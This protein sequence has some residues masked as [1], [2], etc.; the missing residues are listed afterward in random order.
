M[1]SSAVPGLRVSA[2]DVDKLSYSRDLWPRRLLE[3][4][5][6]RMHSEPGCIAWP[7]TSESVARLVEFARREG[8]HL[9]PF[10]AGSGVC[11]AV[12]PDARTVVV[13]LKEMAGFDIEPE[14][15]TLDVGP[16]AMGI[17]LE[18]ELG[19]RGFTIGHFPSSILCST[20]GG[21]IAARGAGQCSG[22]YGK[23]EDMVVSADCVL[24]TGESVTLQRRFGGPTGL[25]LMIGSEGTL[26][27]ITR[28]RLRLHPVPA[29][30]AFVAYSYADI[31]QGWDAM[32]ALFQSGLRPA[33]ARLYDPIDSALMRQ[34]TV[35]D[36]GGAARGASG[37][38]TARLIKMLPT[39]LRA[40]RLLNKA[41][42]AAEGNLLGGVTLVLVFE[43][44]S[45]DVHADRSRAE[46]LCAELGGRALGEGPAR[47]WYQH[48]YGVSY[49]QSPLFR[50]GAFSDTMEVASPWS[51]LGELYDSVR[52][53]LGHHVLVMAHLS[54]AYPDGCSI[55]FTFSGIGR[56]A[57]DALAKY[58]RAWR[59]ALDAAI[60]AGGTL[61]H[62]HGVGRSKAPKLGRELG[63]GVEVI[64]RSMRAW[65]PDGIL[66][67]GA[68]A[69]R[70]PGFEPSGEGTSPRSIEPSVDEHSLSA[71]LPG[72]MPLGVAEEMLG[73]RGLT[74]A[75]A[76]FDADQTVAAWLGAGLPGS[77][78][79]WLDPVRQS[80]SGLAATLPGGEWLDVRAAPRRAVGPDLT[81]LF[82]GARGA[83]G[84][85]RAA[86]LTVERQGASP[87]RELPYGGPRNPPV[88][89]AE[90]QAFA[91]LV[92]AVTGG[93]K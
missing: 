69:T 80:V 71:E 66:N 83:V 12:K 86:S 2:T 47:R 59:D 3:M 32:R 26:G 88:T 10:G 5:A 17:T 11:G 58:D 39:L 63:F 49:R 27:I 6:G 70:D 42:E 35:K 20:V 81:A 74:L 72:D 73:R 52:D 23:I 77:R 37:G 87:A 14:G 1:V 44:S 67:P 61:S 48:R 34:G 54:H 19:R 68:L 84:E 22:L 25:P 16:G 65:D 40:P 38:T 8:L 79:P 64:R 7:R 13:D 55:Y 46:R 56:D 41:I 21:W 36:K 76:S 91:Q 51:K 9:V 78:D 4:R 45:D 50:S 15:P 24:G 29:Q 31:V 53:A 57:D 33:V 90:R 75:L 62:H 18:E 43:G 89:P 93:S 28:A 85:V 92:S 82:V 30:R 60:A